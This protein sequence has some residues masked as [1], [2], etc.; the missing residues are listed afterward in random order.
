MT[1]RV[2]VRR[3]PK[4]AHNLVRDLRYGRPLG[5]SIASRHPEAGANDIGNSD[6]DDLTLL[7]G[8]ALLERD[9]VVVDV[10][11]G[12][13]RP[14]NWLLSHHRENRIYGIELDPEICGATRR[15][16][17]RFAN[18]TVLCGDAT[19]LLPPDATVFYLF[20]PF[21]EEVMRRFV[22]AL[23]ELPPA[24]R[25]RRV[26]YYNY[27]HLNVFA[28]EPGLSVCE[29]PGPTLRSALILV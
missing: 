25:R 20:N 22:A 18:V 10:G 24:R 9:D 8:A 23:K 14:L 27:K 4:I 1:T 15:R 13:G 26:I 5:G 28:D 6:Y 12:K 11:C 21:N 2:L 19:T 7:F 17:R 3:T 16:L 29:I